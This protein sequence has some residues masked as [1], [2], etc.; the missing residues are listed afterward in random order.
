MPDIQV[1][2]CMS[3]ILTQYLTQ[4][5][6]KSYKLFRITPYHSD[7]KTAF[8]LSYIVLPHLFAKYIAFNEKIIDC[9][10]ENLGKALQFDIGHS[11]QP[12]FYAGD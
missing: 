4:S 11:A 5:D 10:A 7:E 2:I 8:D 3:G 9:N 12:V 1:A 6:T